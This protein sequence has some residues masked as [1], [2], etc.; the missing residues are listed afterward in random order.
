MNKAVALSHLNVGVNVVQ[1]ADSWQYYNHP[2]PV[3][4]GVIPFYHIYGG[5]TIVL[6]SLYLGVPFVI[7]PRFQP[8]QCL[9]AIEKY[10]ITVRANV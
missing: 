4:L 8:D 10:K 5:S 7:L 2:N 6:L 3:V 1:Q 9:S